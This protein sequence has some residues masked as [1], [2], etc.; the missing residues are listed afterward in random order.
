MLHIVFYKVKLLW[1]TL[2]K[3][4]GQVMSV[5]IIFVNGTKIKHSEISSSSF[6]FMLQVDL[7][8]RWSET[9][10]YPGWTRGKIH[11]GFDTIH[12]GQIRKYSAN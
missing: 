7:Q 8:N 4:F 3:T 1:V 11:C 10:H 9:V 5:I 6:P 12:F 2:R